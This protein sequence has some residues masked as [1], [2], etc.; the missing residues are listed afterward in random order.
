MNNKLDFLIV[1]KLILKEL[2]NEMCNK[3]VINFVNVSNII[4]KLEKDISKLKNLQ[5]NNKDMKNI[6]V[7][8]LV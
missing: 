4:Q 5:E 7:K 8:I 1:K 2:I 6:I 3:G